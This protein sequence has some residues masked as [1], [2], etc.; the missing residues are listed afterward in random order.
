MEYYQKAYKILSSI[1]K[2]YDAEK[3]LKEIEE[4]NKQTISS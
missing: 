1:D 2:K 4:L 3:V